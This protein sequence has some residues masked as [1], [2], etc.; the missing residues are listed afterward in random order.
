MPV[1][2]VLSGPTAVSR[3]QL[4]NQLEQQLQIRFRGLRVEVHDEGLVLHGRVPTYYSKQL[5]QHLIMAMTDLPIVANK[6]EVR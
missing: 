3:E 4:S 5:A 6:I 1:S 2:E